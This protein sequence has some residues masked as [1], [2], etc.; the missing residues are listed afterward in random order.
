MYKYNESN[1]VMEELISGFCNQYNLGNLLRPPIMVTG[2]LM[3]KMFRVIT[4][5]GEYAVKVLNPDI[6][7]R[8]QALRNMISSE[9]ISNKFKSEISLIAAKEILGQHVIAF[10]S[11]YLMVFDWIDARSLF[12]AEIKE[13]HCKEIGKALGKMHSLSIEIHGKSKNVSIREMFSWEDYLHEAK[14]QQT[15]WF[16][17]YKDNIEKIIKWDVEVINGLL[18]LSNNQVISHRD[19]DPKN[20]MWKNNELYIIDWEAAGYVNP[21]QELVEVLNYWTVDVNGKYDKAKFDAL[22]SEYVKYNNVESVNWRVVLQSSLDGVLGWLEYNLKRALGLEG[23]GSENVEE[24]IKQLK[25]TIDELS[26]CQLN[27]MCLLEWLNE[28]A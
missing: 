23:S 24:G 20:V 28:Y 8:E 3:H 13:F 17:I 9:Q 15:E 7:K 22:L 1:I 6:M 5:I 14:L 26:R 11:Y 21:F 27:M 18:E 19:L 12:G 16:S 25:G 4:E 2:G 10:N